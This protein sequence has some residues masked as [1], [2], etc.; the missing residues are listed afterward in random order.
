MM[1]RSFGKWLALAAALLLSAAVS[2]PVSAEDWPEI[3]G[4]GRHNVWAET[5]ILT[6]FP[7]GGLTVTWRTP[8]RNGYAG[9][10]VAA[11][12]V[13]VSDYQP[14]PKAAPAGS[15]PAAS[16]PTSAPSAVERVLCLSEKTGEILWTHENKEVKY[17]SVSYPYGPRATPTVDGDFVYV[18]GTAGDL[19]CLNVADGKPLWTLNYQKDFNARMPTWGFA[20]A[21]LVY[22]DTLIC[23]AGGEK[24]A[25]IALD[26]K[27]GKEVWHAVKEKPGGIGYSAPILIQ[28]GGVEQLIQW[29][30]G[31]ISSLNPKTGE[32]YWEQPYPQ[33]SM[34]VATPTLDGNLL[35]VTAYFHGPMMLQLAADKPAAE[36]LWKGKSASP[37]KPDGLHATMATPIVR[38][39]YIYGVCSYG[40]FRC[41]NAKTGERVWETLDVVK[42]NARWASAFITRNGER[43]F[44]NNDRGE[45]II[46]E[47]SPKGY[48]EISRTQLIKPTTPGGGN[49]QSSGVNWV[50]PAYA[51]R[52]II[53][54]NDTEI[55]SASL[56]K[57]P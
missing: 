39:G 4:K 3:Q 40:P 42:E 10:A 47:L 36:L 13:F 25:V 14:A 48:A 8:I 55:I 17:D 18:L 23:A 12:R 32:V 52:H 49:R 9:P 54:R 44:I 57:A 5:G 16:Q 31:G 6:T 7:A 30:G 29:H 11:G 15:Q 22:G 1:K 21:P 38:D 26:K 56:E 51:N 53:I 45:L 19:Y 33:E 41:L 46:A 24:G 37:E 43:Y 34:P 28:A 27:T 20:A 35:F 50:L 2:I